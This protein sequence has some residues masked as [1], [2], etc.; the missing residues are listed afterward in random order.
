MTGEVGTVNY[1]LWRNGVLLG[2]VRIPFPCN[3]EKSLFGMLEVESTFADIDEL[4]QTRSP[5]LPGRPVMQTLM[6]DAHHGPGPVAL[7]EATEQEARGV[8]AEAVLEVRDESGAAI[9]VDMLL[10]A[11]MPGPIPDRGEIVDICRAYSIPISPWTLS[12]R[13]HTRPG[14]RTPTR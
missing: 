12:V 2:R 10:I 13:R 7:R 5:F 8:P 3:D 14:N 9:D 1:S 4:M 11:R 6:R